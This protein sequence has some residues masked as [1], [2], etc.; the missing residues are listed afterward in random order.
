MESGI[1]QNMLLRAAENCV[2]SG[3]VG[4]A[5][6]LE[7]AP[8]SAA[9]ERRNQDPSN[10][11]EWP[12]SLAPM[13]PWDALRVGAAYSS[14]GEKE[15]AYRAFQEAA[16]QFL[17]ESLTEEAINAYLLALELKPCSPESLA[18]LAYL[19]VQ[20]GQPDK[21]VQI[22]E[23]AVELDPQELELLILLGDLYR[24]AGRLDDAEKTL[25]SRD[26]RGGG[27]HCQAFQLAGRFLKQ[28]NLE[29]TVEQIR[30][31]IVPVLSGEGQGE[32]I[33]LLR[34]VLER[35]SQHSGAL[36]TL[37]EVYRHTNDLPELIPI[38]E[39]LSKI[40]LMAG[41]EAGAIAALRELNRLAPAEETYR[42]RL[43][44]LGVQ[45]VVESAQS[46]AIAPPPLPT[47]PVSE[48]FTGDT[49]D[50]EVA[51]EDQ[52]EG[53]DE[54][55]E[56]SSTTTS[57]EGLAESPDESPDEKL[58]EPPGDRVDESPNAGPS[59]SPCTADD[60]AFEAAYDASSEASPGEGRQ[61][62]LNQT[63]V[64]TEDKVTGDNRD[65]RFNQA[66]NVSP[67]EPWD[68]DDHDDL[69]DD[70]W[71]EALDGTSEEHRGK[72]ADNDSAENAAGNPSGDLIVSSLTE[73]DG[74]VEGNEGA[75]IDADLETV[76]V[77]CHRLSE[78]SGEYLAAPDDEILPGWGPHRLL[79]GGEV[80]TSGARSDLIIQE[81]PAHFVEQP[82]LPERETF[83]S[84]RP[85]DLSVNDDRSEA[86]TSQDAT[87][88]IS[89]AYRA[90][91][92]SYLTVQQYGLAKKRD[93]KGEE[94]LRKNLSLLQGLST[95]I[96]CTLETSN[97]GDLREADSANGAAAGAQVPMAD[98]AVVEGGSA[99]DSAV[100]ET[101]LSRRANCRQS[102][103]GKNYDDARATNRIQRRRLAR[104][105]LRLSVTVGPPDHSWQESTQT[106]DVSPLGI[107]FEL[108]LERGK[109]VQ[110]GMPLLIQMAMPQAL[111]IYPGQQSACAISAVVC[112]V[113]DLNDKKRVGAEFGIIES[114]EN[115]L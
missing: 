53:N 105:D 61:E 7:D 96:R 113:S 111:Q 52:D 59:E 20:Q 62:I 79:P 57:D 28:D 26:V 70:E 31:C 43:R 38:L 72:L 81:W 75:E 5:A 78:D 65:Q 64:E 83:K 71:D 108:S 112:Y 2:A 24:S 104:T 67:A 74:A 13:D 33:E 40:S 39:Q 110:V 97:A 36:R 82:T 88:A 107:G 17:K 94:W 95:L 34:G 101:C 6:G 103:N 30:S 115:E 84:L 51:D 42:K 93:A 14:T 21:A 77:V 46:T 58:D 99:A 45:D 90:A 106:F 3:Q 11:L 73:P 50:D 4:E 91:L 10:H 22:V 23:T 49:P 56:A 27:R 98:A 63:P 37:A 12:D 54:Y 8:S 44:I 35:D 102:R 80:V 114:V 47:A 69:W 89:Q 9:L 87:Q 86:E 25:S 109:D 68:G 92:E 48:E 15:L 55:P 19:Y 41:D 100:P 66:W 60:T 29:G 32:A 18:S 76:P 16:G 1:R 85:A